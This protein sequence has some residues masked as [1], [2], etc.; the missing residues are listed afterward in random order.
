MDKNHPTLT[1]P[2]GASTTAAASSRSHSRSRADLLAWVA[3]LAIQ[4]GFVDFDVYLVELA[5]EPYCGMYP[6]H[7]QPW[8]RCTCPLDVTIVV[9]IGT[10]RAYRIE[11]VCDGIP[12]PVAGRRVQ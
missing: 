7:D 11:L 9:N 5:H 3:V 1:P 6:T 2:F 10:P 12:L 8:H 4:W